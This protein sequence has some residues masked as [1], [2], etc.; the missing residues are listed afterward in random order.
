MT[1]V[2]SFQR[3]CQGT[4]ANAEIGA[5]PS[6]VGPG[7]TDDLTWITGI[8]ER[9]EGDVLLACVLIYV[10]YGLRCGDPRFLGSKSGTT[11]IS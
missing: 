3:A 1:I 2:I 4:I 8:V 6:R 11:F 9:G 10:D 7:R 5:R